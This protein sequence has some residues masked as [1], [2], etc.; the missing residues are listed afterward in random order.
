LQ[1][2][3]TSSPPFLKIIG[4]ITTCTGA[5]SGGKTSPLSSPWMEIIAAIDLSEIP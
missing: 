5:I 4:I 1:T 3:S 2:A